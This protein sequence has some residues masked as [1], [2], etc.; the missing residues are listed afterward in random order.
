M[1]TL[2]L[3]NEEIC[4][5]DQNGNVNPIDPSTICI[6][7]LETKEE[8][9]ICVP[10]ESS[11]NSEVYAFKNHPFR[12]IRSIFGS[13]LNLLPMVLLTML[14][15]SGVA[16]A[17]GLF[18]R[19][20]WQL[21]IYSKRKMQS[22]WGHLS[23]EVIYQ[24][25]RHTA[26][27]YMLRFGFVLNSLT[28]PFLGLVLLMLVLLDFLT[29]P[30]L[31]TSSNLKVDPL[32]K[33]FKLSTVTLISGETMCHRRFSFRILLFAVF[34]LVAV[35]KVFGSFHQMCKRRKDVSRLSRFLMKID[36]INEIFN[37]NYHLMIKFF[38]GS[39]FNSITSS[40]GFLLA[41]GTLHF[42]LGS[43]LRGPK[44]GV[45]AEPLDLPP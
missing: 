36:A 12:I 15:V 5:Y 40:E 42:L 41:D 7:S 37:A 32:F 27:V 34:V 24:D 31:V 2:R 17:L 29:L 21:V 18:A 19:F 3:S 4:L 6:R 22:A 26:N 30:C 9:H 25:S 16:L 20:V 1:V 28:F 35:L 39:E 14:I 43:G 11:L 13:T 10:L 33:T 38:L 45:A 23:S 8:G 44:P